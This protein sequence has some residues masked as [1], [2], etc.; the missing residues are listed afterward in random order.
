MGLGR[1][2]KRWIPVADR[3]GFFHLPLRE[4]VSPE[5][6]KNKMCLLIRVRYV[7]REEKR[8]EEKTAHS[9]IISNR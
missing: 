8:F 5:L 7:L 1:C 2:Y 9:K 6:V 4:V 3:W